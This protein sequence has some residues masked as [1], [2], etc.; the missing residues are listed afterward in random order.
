MT[1]IEALIDELEKEGKTTF[2]LADIKEKAE[3]YSYCDCFDR[4]DQHRCDN[5]WICR[6]CDK[7]IR[8]KYT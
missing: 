5:V 2:T 1:D 4:M 8:Q 6:D 7:E 3:K